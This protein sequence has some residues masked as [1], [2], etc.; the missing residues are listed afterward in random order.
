MSGGFT[1]FSMR[2]KE[3]TPFGERLFRARKEAKLTQPKLA[4]LAGMAPSTLAEAEYT[5][6]G[7]S[8]TPQLA[9]ACGVLAEWLATGDG[10][11]HPPGTAKTFADHIK[12]EAEQ[13]PYELIER[14]LA[15][16]VIVGE[17]KRA[18]LDQVRKLAAKSEEF[19]AAWQERIKSQNHRPG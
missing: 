15:A 9:K 4:A 3:R 16:L 18:I 1:L 11:K 6:Q 19:R 5:A 8:F 14:G 7:S 17:D 13:D 10:P 2:K 12:A